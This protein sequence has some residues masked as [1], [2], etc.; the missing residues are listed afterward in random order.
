MKN[1]IIKVALTIFIVICLIQLIDAAF[2]L[3]NKPDTY[4]F[5]IGIFILICIFV[6]FSYITSYSIKFI[7]NNKKKDL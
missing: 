1:T 3:M 7:K 2:Y 4:L 5:N 6:A